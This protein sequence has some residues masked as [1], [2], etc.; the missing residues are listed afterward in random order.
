MKLFTPIFFLIALGLPY[1]TVSAADIPDDA[2]MDVIEHSGSEHYEHEIE[3]PEA[4]HDGHEMN[5]DG[6][7]DSNEVEAPENE[8]PE[9]ES[10]EIET[11]EKPEAQ[12]TH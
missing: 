5:H 6:K 1:S 8:T 9:V 12:E 4:A 7:E 10:P 11:P 2:T 3:L